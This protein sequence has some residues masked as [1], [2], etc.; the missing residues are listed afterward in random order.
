[1]VYLLSQ[2]ESVRE[3]AIVNKVDGIRHGAAKSR[4]QESIHIVH[5]VQV[6][7]LADRNAVRPEGFRSGFR[8]AGDRAQTDYSAAGVPVVTTTTTTTTIVLT[9]AIGTPPERWQKDTTG[10]DNTK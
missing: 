10:Q 8:D 7:E 9:L 6:D 4:Q 3:D 5:P 2:I 1:L